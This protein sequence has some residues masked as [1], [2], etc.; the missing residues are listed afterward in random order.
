MQKEKISMMKMIVAAMAVMVFASTLEAHERTYV[1]RHVVVTRHVVVDDG[2]GCDCGCAC[3][4]KCK[5]KIRKVKNRC[6]QICRVVTEPV[7]CVVKTV[8]CVVKPVCCVK[9]PT[10]CEPNVGEP[11][12]EPTAP[13]Q[14][15]TPVPMPTF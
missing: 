4:R 15:L 14:E 2:C 11:V 5:C 7:C 10:C 8:C 3:E 12:V 6:K 1:E 13:T 9:V